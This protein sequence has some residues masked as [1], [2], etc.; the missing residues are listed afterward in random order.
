MNSR[1]LPLGV[2]TEKTGMIGEPLTI[3]RHA[4]MNPYLL[5]RTNDISYIDRYFDFLAHCMD[6][7][8]AAVF[9]AALPEASA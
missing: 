3:L 4:L 8:P 6:E 1:I 2:R 5:D 7:M 9:A